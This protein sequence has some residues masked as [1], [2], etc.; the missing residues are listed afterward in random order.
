MNNHN[1]LERNIFKKMFNNTPNFEK[2]KINKL[3]LVVNNRIRRRTIHSNRIDPKNSI[4]S[5]RKNSL[6]SQSINTY[7]SN[8]NFK[9][10]AIHSTIDINSSSQINKMSSNSSYQNQSSQ[11][12]ISINVKKDTPYK[13][14][15]NKTNFIGFHSK[16]DK[17]KSF[18]VMKV[19]EKKENSFNSKKENTPTLFK[20]FSMNNKHFLMKKTNNNN[21]IDR[22]LDCNPA[23]P[24][25]TTKLKIVNNDN[26]VIRINNINNKNNEITN[27]ICNIDDK[28]GNI[29][30][31]ENNFSNFK[32]ILQNFTANTNN[33][34]N[35]NSVKNNTLGNS[36][37]NYNDNNKIDEN[38]DLNSVNNYPV[39]MNLNSK[40][41]KNKLNYNN[42][43]YL[44][45]KSMV[46]N[47]K[48]SK[49]N[50]R[51]TNNRNYPFNKTKTHYL[52]KIEFIEDDYFDYNQDKPAELTKDEKIIY[53]D[54]IMKNYFKIKLLG[55]GGCGIV[56]LCMN[57]EGKECAVKQISKKTGNSLLNSTEE[58]L[59]IARNEIKILNF[60]KNYQN[61]IRSEF[62]ISENIPQIYEFYE[63]N[64]DIWFSFEKGGKSLSSLCFKIKGEFEKSERVYHIQKGLFLQMIFEN[65][66]QFKNLI[67]KIIQGIDFI[68][69]C[70][71]IHSD[72]KPDNILIDYDYDNE[73]E[74]ITVKNVKIIDYGSA[75]FYS[76]TS[77]IT[78][79]TPEYLCPE[80][81]GGNKKFLKEITEDTNKKYINSIDMWSLG[82]TILEM[83]L[84]CPIWMSY[85][86][87]VILNGKV[88]YSNGLF[89]C[90][91]RDG[92]KI[93]QKQI[94]LKKNLNKI[95]K[96]S[97]LYMFN[98]EDK[99]SF[100]D[101]LGKMLEID[102]K[103]RITAQ[104][105]LN[106]VF[107]KE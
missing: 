39:N 82:I 91:G 65:I 7:K 85:K 46:S 16:L 69:N 50:N 37:N 79:N 14:T 104:Q 53:G 77:A 27:N 71:I 42:Y 6:G 73:H 52:K 30:N 43:Y 20:H 34:Y 87:K 9:L 11:S 60:L 45:N 83:C 18:V 62:P 55:K 67:R 107:L 97:M 56:W 8:K 58:N 90:K 22:H 76:N 99:D 36:I 48:Y 63:D 12:K 4:S 47:N 25:L 23:F 68:N 19:N 98:E 24:F 57:L 105:A 64:Y 78:S 15:V 5:I 38:K 88:Y 31:N 95:I 10:S 17:N 54:R 86:S 59:K 106:H 51:S 32:N 89:G 40:L 44:A 101:L 33:L 21:L 35:S 41:N 28:K 61:S 75:F 80:I 103:K 100:V 49:I 72:I 92:T 96:N 1:N 81:T 29:N 93:Y 94:S 3:P 13:L 2:C 66:T 26:L 70:G 74:F 84:C 102:Y